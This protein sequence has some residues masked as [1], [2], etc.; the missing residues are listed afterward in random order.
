MRFGVR[1]VSIILLHL[2]AFSMGVQYLHSD[3]PQSEKVPFR[4]HD[5]SSWAVTKA[6]K[7]ENT[8]QDLRDPDSTFQVLI[9]DRDSM[10]SD[11]L[12][13][14]LTRDRNCQAS[15]VRSADLMDSVV[16]GKAQLVVI[17]ADL[18]HDTK[19]GFDLAH[20]VRRAHPAVPIVML[21]K[22]STHDSVINAFRSGA[23]GVFSRQQPVADFLDCVEHVRKGFIWA[24]ELETTLLLNALRSIPSPNMAMAS[25]SSPLTM[26]ELQV[27]KC[28]ARGKTNK[29]IACELG[30]SEHT[31]K[32]Y[33]FRASDKL[34]VSNR[35]ELL[36]YLTQ[37]GQTF[38]RHTAEYPEPNLRAD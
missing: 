21:L 4:S 38:R 7:D 6:R 15:A 33:L 25:D 22:Q 26:R 13:T 16:N 30:L 2:V 27:V 35:V 5:G 3:S 24:G 37:R 1:R 14:A 36:F 34:G 28:A 9:V 20:T 29:V 23:R 17:G 19:T 31:V 8:L 10:S 32:N 12:A 11:L 18:N